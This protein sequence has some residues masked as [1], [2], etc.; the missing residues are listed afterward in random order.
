MISRS[1]VT[2]RDIPNPIVQFE[3]HGF[4]DASLSAYG[5]CVY[6]KFVKRND[7]DICV[8]LVA[9]KSR[10]APWRNQPTIPRLELN[11]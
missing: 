9:S 2:H 8:T 10:I 4:S 11:G 1:M 5:A 6:L 3:M 7:G